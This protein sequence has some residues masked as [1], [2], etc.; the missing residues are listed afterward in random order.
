MAETEAIKVATL[1]LDGEAQDWS[2]H[3][4]VTLGHSTVTT[5]AEFTRRL[6]ERFDRRDPKEH[7]VELT[8]LKQTGSPNTYISNFLRLSVMVQDLSAARMIYNF[9]YEL[10][11]QLRGLVRS[12]RPTTLHDAVG[13]TRDLQDA[14]PR[15]RT[16]YPQ[17]Q[18]FQPKGKDVRIPPSKGNQGRVQLDDDARRELK[19]KR[20][21]FTCQDPWAL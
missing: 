10:A 6:I 14:L 15:T 18:A 4:M 11:E 7:F 16:P 8:R 3:G 17:R 1:H 5:Y 20:L 19:K 13:R 9:I 21:C 2:F 12:T